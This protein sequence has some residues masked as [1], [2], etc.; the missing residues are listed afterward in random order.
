[1]K[2]I[3]E[4]KEIK[5]LDNKQIPI[6]KNVNLDFFEKQNTCISSKEN[7]DFDICKK[8]IAV[9]AGQ[10]EPNSGSISYARFNEIRNYIFGYNNFNNIL[11]NPIVKPKDVIEALFKKEEILE[12]NK[13]QINTFIKLLSLEDV[14]SQP[15]SKITSSNRDLLNILFL[16]IIKPRVLFL[17]DFSLKT[18]EEGL[19]IAFI[20]SLS[21]YLKKYNITLI[22][23][24]NNK[25]IINSELCDRHILI[26]DQKIVAD[27]IISHHSSIDE[28]NVDNKT[29]FFNLE[30]ELD[31]SLKK[32]Q[33]P[34]HSKTINLSDEDEEFKKNI[35]SFIDTRPINNKTNLKTLSNIDD[36]DSFVNKK[37][38]AIN[39]SK[40]KTTRNTSNLH[41]KTQ[42]L[43]E[44]SEN[45]ISDVKLKTQSYNQDFQK[46]TPYK[47]N[48]HKEKPTPKNYNDQKIQDIV[49][50]YF[51]QKDLEKQIKSPEFINLSVDL[52]NK[53]FEHYDQASRLIDENDPD[54]RY[55][56][57]R[58]SKLKTDS[59]YPG[60]ADDGY[61]TKMI[62]LEELEIEKQKNQLR[63]NHLKDIYKSKTSEFEIEEDYISKPTVNLSYK[64]ANKIDKT[65]KSVINEVTTDELYDTDSYTPPPSP[66]P[67]RA[68][69]KRATNSFKEVFTKNRTNSIRHEYDNDYVS[70]SN[71]FEPSSS[72]PKT[73]R[74]SNPDIMKNKKPDYENKHYQQNIKT[75]K[76]KQRSK[77]NIIEMLYEEGIDDLE[78]YNKENDD[79]ED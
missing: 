8:F 65:L 48:I 75:Q 71:N 41:H 4:L 31:L 9:L 33:L 54:H 61:L 67:I 19:E 42:T 50:T 36:N 5:I 26:D 51:L 18:G 1:M 46:N 73:T 15:M 30:D 68:K 39:L 16:L 32:T 11:N 62:L 38:E 60:N 47:Q 27:K 53:V 34:K 21:I 37:V 72:T 45:L 49:D 17:R 70:S 57:Y 64:N 79:S 77:K 22:I 74:I 23:A 25:N 2:K 76:I 14:L 52:Q 7:T 6:L 3:I 12:E 35:A 28:F 29:K 69:T 40:Y 10:Q 44:K 43:K 55:D 20:K 66:P 78:S 58:T 56:P 59:L 63:D 13:K 24:T